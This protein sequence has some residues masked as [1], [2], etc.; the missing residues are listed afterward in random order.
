EAIKDLSEEAGANLRAILDGDTSIPLP[1]S[2]PTGYFPEAIERSHSINERF[3]A[4][5]V[6][7]S[8][9]RWLGFL[10]E[11][12]NTLLLYVRMEITKVSDGKV[13]EAE[14]REIC[15]KMILG[16]TE[17]AAQAMKRHIDRVKEQILA[18]ESRSN[19]HNWEDHG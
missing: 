16:D 9:N 11:R 10:L 1:G 18:L 13:S 7:R 19:Q 17:G 2:A 5:I 4:Y 12:L 8:G 15:E 6:Q 14:H 3:H